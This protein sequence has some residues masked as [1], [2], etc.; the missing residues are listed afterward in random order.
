[1]A[2]KLTLEQLTK[3]FQAAEKMKQIYSLKDR[4]DSKVLVLNGSLTVLKEAL[5]IIAEY[6]PNARGGS[7]HYALKKSTQY[8]KAYKEIKQHLRDSHG[9]KT[10]IN[11]VLKS[12]KVVIPVL[13]TKKRVYFEKILKIFDVINS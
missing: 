1:M 2:G 7:F 9:R 3:G 10:D 12:L 8:S 5:Q 6:F 11:H 13:D 4:E